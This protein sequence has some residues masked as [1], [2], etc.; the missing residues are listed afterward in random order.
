M[1]EIKP[2]PATPLSIYAD[3]ELLELMALK[4]DVDTGHQAF[5]EFYSRFKQDLFDSINSICRTY[6]NKSE[7]SGIVFNNT[8]FNAF[9][10]AHTFSVPEGT[11]PEGVRL[12]ILGWLV[13]I[14]RNVLKAQFSPK[15]RPDKEKEEAVYRA[16]LKSGSSSRKAESYQEKIVQEAMRQIP[17]ERDRE[18]FFI[19]WLYYEQGEKGQ[20][21]KLPDDIYDELCVKYNTTEQNIRQIISRTNRIVKD[22]LQKHFKK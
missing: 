19:Y 7:L 2:L 12:K 13:T 21:K 16:M 6:T 1:E 4:D 17:K 14:A 15:L 11:P 8:F 20:A 9:N 22:Y 3:H 5:H 10:Y 18:I